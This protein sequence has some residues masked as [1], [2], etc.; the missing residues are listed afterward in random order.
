[1]N[2]KKIVFVVPSLRMGGAEK[3]AVNIMNRLDQ[4]KYSI[5]LLLFEKTGSLL[6]EINP[7][8][9]MK[10]L[11]S[12][13]KMDKTIKLYREIRSIKPDIVFSTIINANILTGM[14]SIFYRD[15]LYIGRETTVHSKLLEKNKPF[16]KKII[17]L[18]Y[19]L[20]ISR[21]DI[22]IAQS[23]F[24]KNE[25]TQLFKVKADKIIIL[26]NPVDIKKSAKGSHFSGRKRLLSVGR[27]HSLKRPILLLNIFSHLD[28][29]YELIILGE[30]AEKEGLKKEIQ[31]LGIDD[32]VTLMGQCI[33]P[34]K[35][36]REAAALLV[37]SE[38]DSYPNVMMEALASGTRVVAFDVPGAINEILND[39]VKGILVPNN[40]IQAYQEAIEKIVVEAI[41]KVKVAATVKAQS[42]ENY[43]DRLEEIF[44]L[45]EEMNEVSD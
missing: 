31:R 43:L 25:L 27:L 8:I 41:P 1:M 37:T 11:V 13:N 30:G 6:E 18:W 10:E 21:L 29:S 2:K 24:M 7:A 23:Q 39:P 33:D 12:K 4:K 5:H 42:W 26:S 22:V 14:V 35:Y 9:K 17:A 19:R 20:F 32:R 36:Y 38:Y 44:L 34:T 40:D 15:C 16:V 28:T 45:K 3:N